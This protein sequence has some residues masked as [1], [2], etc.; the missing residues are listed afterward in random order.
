MMPSNSPSG[1]SRSLQSFPLIVVLIASGL[2]FKQEELVGMVVTQLASSAMSV[3]S[4][5]TGIALYGLIM[6]RE[7]AAKQV[8]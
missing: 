1:S 4:L 3:V 6:S 7:D 8:G 5:S 2:L